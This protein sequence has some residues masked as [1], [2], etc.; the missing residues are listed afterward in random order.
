MLTGDIDAISEILIARQYPNLHAQVMLVPH[1]G[2]RTSS[3]FSFIEKVKPDLAFASVSKNNQWNLPARDVVERYQQQ[4]I[5]WLDTGNA[6][7]ISI[8]VYEKQWLIEKK[9]GNQ[10]EP[11]YRQIVRKG[12]E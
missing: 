12:L 6:G 3:L 1:H 9:R 7:A 10:Y 11:W 2:S 8:S 4:G 5:K